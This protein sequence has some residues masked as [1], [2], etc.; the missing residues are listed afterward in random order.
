M[1]GRLI[2]LIRSNRFGSTDSMRRRSLRG[3]SLA[4]AILSLLL[5]ASALAAVG[6]LTQ[7]PGIAGCISDT[8]A[9]P[10]ADGTALISSL[11]VTISPDGT[12][13]Y[14]ASFNSDAVAI[15]DRNTTTGALTQK[16]GTA[17][18]ISDTGAGPCADGTALD[19]ALSVT[20]SPDGTSV[21]AASATSDAVAIFDRNTTTGALTQKPGTAGCISD[22]GAGPCA[23]GTA[24]S[25]P[26][27]VTVSP[28]GTS[29]YLASLGSNAVAIFDRN[30]TTGALTQKPGTAGCISD[31][32]AGPCADGTALNGARSVTVSPDGANAYVA[33]YNSN[34][35]AIFD[36]NTTTGALTQ[37]P[38]TAGCI[39]EDGTSAACI[40]G[41]ALFG[42]SSVTVSSDGT[43]ANVAS[44]NSDAVAIFDRNTTTG[45]LTQKAGTAGCI[46]DDGT[47][48]ECINGTALLGATSVTISPDGTTAYVAS[49]DSD[50]VAIF[51]RNTTT[52]ALTQKPG[53][54]GCISDTGAGPCADGTALDGAFSVTISRDGTSAY[55]ASQNSDAV[56]VFDRDA[57]P[58]TTIDSGPSGP[59]NDITPTFTY[60]SNESGS[61]FECRVD[62]SSFAACSGPGA[63]NTTPTLS[64]GSHTFAVRAIDPASN[65]DPSPAT[66][67][68]IVDTAA[69]V[70]KITKKP[71]KKLKTSKKKA[72]VR[73]SFSAD[74]EATFE[75]QLT[76]AAT[77][78]A[79]HPSASRR[80]RNAARARSTRSRSRPPTRSA[81]SSRRPPSSNS[82]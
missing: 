49:Q 43:S 22:T 66:R 76:E 24:L 4:A 65:P 28:D 75:C 2:H 72:K 35:V 19:G 39:S 8:G 44:L 67:S 26:Y 68:F 34:A 61:S 82:G 53:T 38:G 21:Y 56:A 6:G 29:A 11:S 77:G 51:D 79:L 7:K 37:K 23:D 57:A 52:G 42:A 36:R 63:S 60:S 1:A 69:P 30:T 70:T 48:S 16:P 80:N 33:S 32:G 18:C 46:S 15:F 3:A 73:V 40:D 27:S 20:I 9:G 58:E 14:V 59:T 74:E 62:A 81:T 71:K 50:A 78:P 25:V 45:A 10:C 12:S 31:T 54:A 17:G 13:A 5:A 64:D 55:V 41:S 47:S